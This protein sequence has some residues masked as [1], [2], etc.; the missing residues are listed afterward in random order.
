MRPL[1]EKINLNSLVLIG[2]PKKFAFNTLDDFNTYG[3]EDLMQVKSFCRDYIDNIEDNI[4]NNRGIFFF[5]S[6][7][8]G[9]S[10][11]ASI[12]LQVAY[13]HRYSCKRITFS[14]YVSQ[15]TNSWKDSD[16]DSYDICKSAEFLVLEEIGKEIDSKI[17]APILEDLLRYRDE[18]NLVTIICS[19]INL[20]TISEQYGNSVASVMTGCMTP[21]KI[22]SDDRR[23][24][25]F[26]A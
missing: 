4:H 7:G 11:L 13:I 19:N 9:K 17:T 18:H 16:D 26:N 3:N 1:R 5:G 23:M 6:N 15:Y 21:I 12:I 20:K 24:E 10:M 14:N 22:S 8:V 25:V 2:V